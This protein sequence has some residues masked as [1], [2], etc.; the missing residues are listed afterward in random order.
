ML[1][2][3]NVARVALRPRSIERVETVKAPA[4]GSSLTVGDGDVEG[5]GVG[6]SVV[7]AAL[8]DGAAEV[9]T[10]LGDAVF[11][12]SAGVWPSARGHTSTVS[13]ISRA[14]ASALRAVQLRLQRPPPVPAAASVTSPRAAE[15]AW[16]TRRV[17]SSTRSRRPAG[18]AN[19]GT[20]P[21]STHGLTIRL[22]RSEHTS[23]LSTWRATRCEHGCQLVAVIAAQAGDQKCPERPVDLATQPV[24]HHVRVGGAHAHRLAELGAVESLAQVQIEERPV[25]VGKTGRGGPDEVA[26]RR[27]LGG[28][29]GGDRLVRHGDQLVLVAVRH[30]LAGLEPG[31]AL[32]ADDG[33]EPGPQAVGVPQ[34]TQPLGEDQEGVRHCVRGVLAMPEHRVGEVEEPVAVAVVDLCERVAVRVQDAGDEVRVGG[35]AGA[36]SAGRGSHAGIVRRAPALACGTATSAH[37][38]S[39][40]PPRSWVGVRRASR[41]YT[42][43]PSGHRVRTVTDLLADAAIAADLVREAGTL[44]RDLRGPGLSVATKTSVSD[45]V[46]A[47]ALAAERLV[48]DHLA[49]WRPDD[50]IVAEEGHGRASSSGRTWVIDPVD[51]T[52]NFVHGSTWWCSAAALVHGDPLDGPGDVLVGAIYHP[53]EDVMY[54]GGPGLTSTR[55]GEPIGAIVDRPLSQSCVSTYLHPPFFDAPEGDVFAR[56]VRR[57][58]TLRMLGSGSLDLAAVAQGHLGV[59]VQHSVA[60]WDWWPGSAIVRGAGGTTRRVDVDGKQWSVAGAPTAVAEVCAALEEVSG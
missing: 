14:A 28:P 2:S 9:G 4:S 59:F 49:A 55:N 48:V 36:A 19:I 41:P 30:P 18:A 54:V 15:P 16:A 52:Y 23:H 60:S 10:T 20:V 12:S 24:E 11:A 31:Q 17:S 25:A 43:C 5:V 1:L 29:F 39:Y 33:V 26:Q 8:G 50:G 6:A 53:H 22:R 13:R 27:L 34:L 58:A 3:E 40:A 35:L 56:V 7:A 45:V 37:L 32:A 38:L 21:S 51:G 44:A 46:R 47:G 42:F 57:A